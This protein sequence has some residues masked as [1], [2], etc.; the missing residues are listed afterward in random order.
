MEFTSY[1]FRLV[2]PELKD[3][4][5]EHNIPF[6]HNMLKAELVKLLDDKLGEISQPYI[7]KLELLNRDKIEL[8]C[9]NEKIKT[10]KNK[11][12]NLIVKLNRKRYVTNLKLLLMA[13]KRDSIDIVKDVFD[14]IV[15]N[16]LFEETTD[17]LRFELRNLWETSEYQN[18]IDYNFYRNVFGLSFFPISTYNYNPSPTLSRDDVFV[19]LT[20]NG[21]RISGFLRKGDVV[22]LYGLDYQKDPPKFNTLFSEKRRE[23]DIYV[24]KK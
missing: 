5:K 22:M 14:Q 21:Y 17:Q 10:V 23:Y 12:S 19:T 18:S 3:Q 1:R 7:D 24:L 20:K 4:C 2:I 9:K 11:K 16:V 13:Y 6:K 15:K 8:M